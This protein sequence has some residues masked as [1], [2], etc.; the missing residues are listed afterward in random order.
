MPAKKEATVQPL[1]SVDQAPAEPVTGATMKCWN[2][3]NQGTKSRLDSEGVCPT[4]GFDIKT[5]YNG[6]IETVRAQIR[7][8]KE[9]SNLAKLQQSFQKG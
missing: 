4:C 6:D 5:V 3:A 1:D 2:C 8:D 7:K 9:A